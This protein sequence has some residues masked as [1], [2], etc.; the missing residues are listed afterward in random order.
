MPPDRTGSEPVASRVPLDLKPQ[1]IAVGRPEASG[2]GPGCRK[3]WELTGTGVQ[4]SRKP[5]S[6]GFDFQLIG[7]WLFPAPHRQNVLG[8]LS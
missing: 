7:K 4:S 3:E 1:E 2:Q 8:R 5:D 6:L